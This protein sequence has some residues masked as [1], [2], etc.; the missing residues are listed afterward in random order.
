MHPSCDGGSNSSLSNS[1][2]SNNNNNSCSSSSIHVVQT[3]M[4]KQSTPSCSSEPYCLPLTKMW[5][6]VR[7]T[8]LFDCCHVQPTLANRC[9]ATLS[10]LHLYQTSSSSQSTSADG[11][12]QCWNRVFGSRVTGSTTLAGSGRVVSQVS[13]TDPVSDPIL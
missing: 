7:S 10:T 2:S 8:S 4:R 6:P 11:T 12:F 5:Y 3:L 9:P 1:S 13:V